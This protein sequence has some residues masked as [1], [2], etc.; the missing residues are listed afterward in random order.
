VKAKRVKKLDPEAPL[1]A[2]AARIVRTRLGELRALGP[3]ALEPDASR[4]QHDLRIAAKRLRYVLETTGFVFGEPAAVGRKRAR[5]LQGVLGDLH[6]C[7]VMLPRISAHVGDLQARDAAAIRGR[8]GRT[9]IEPEAVGAA[10]NRTAYRGLAMLAAHTEAR[11]DVLFQRFAKLWEKLEADG[12]W[13]AL[14]AAVEA[15]LHAAHERRAAVAPA[16]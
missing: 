5:D 1:A 7:D 14:E 2:N 12:T 3:E 11:R 8:A 16:G 15:K 6:D 10:P 9:G 4:K 13:D